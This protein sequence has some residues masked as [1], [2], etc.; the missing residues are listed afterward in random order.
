MYFKGKI[1]T[2]ESR[3]GELNAYIQE[4]ARLAAELAGLQKQT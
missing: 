3:P 2:S 1:G 4:N